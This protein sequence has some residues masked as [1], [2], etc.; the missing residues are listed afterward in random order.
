[1]KTKIF[2]SMLVIALAAA[3][4]GGATMAI[5][6]DAETSVGNTFTAGTVDITVGTTTLAVN[7]GNMAPG[8]TRTGSFTVTNA[9]TLAL[10]FDVSAVGSGALFTAQGV[11]P[12]NTPATIGPLPQDVVLAPG[13]SSVVT[14]AVTLPLTAGNEYQGDS[15][16]VNL[17]I[18][19][20]QTANN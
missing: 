16:I 6:T 11:A 3:L 5:F 12:G 18:A 13:A 8:D 15:G 9:G 1:M 14:F 2:M 7:S 19:A 17:T 10:R 20:E 4:V